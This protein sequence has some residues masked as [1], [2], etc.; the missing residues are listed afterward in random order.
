MVSLDIHAHTQLTRVCYVRVRACMRRYIF[1]YIYF[2]MVLGFSY[3][4]FFAL[5]FVNIFLCCCLKLFLGF[6]LLLATERRANSE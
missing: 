6:R 4:F 2:S 1:E 5:F 3:F